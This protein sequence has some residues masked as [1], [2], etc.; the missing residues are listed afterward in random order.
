MGRYLEGWE[1]AQ[2]RGSSRNGGRGGEITV[3][4]LCVC[5]TTQKLKAA[6]DVLS[7]YALALPTR[8]DF[9][10]HYLCVNSCCDKGSDIQVS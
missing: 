8:A 4:D 7:S 2:S 1:D 10:I 9:E 6:S 3:Y 5:G